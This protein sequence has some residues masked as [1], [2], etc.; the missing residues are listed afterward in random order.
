MDLYQDG[1]PLPLIMQMLG[2]QSMATT[3]AFYAFATQQ[4]MTDAIAAVTPPPLAQP[5]TWQDETTLEALYRL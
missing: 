4:M 5:A 3:S 1:V 2:H